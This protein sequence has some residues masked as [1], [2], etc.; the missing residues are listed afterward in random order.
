[1]GRQLNCRAGFTEKVDGI[2]QLKRFDIR[3]KEKVILIEDVISTGKSTFQ[4][5]KSVSF[6]GGIPSYKIYCLVNRSGMKEKN[7]LYI[8]SLIDKTMP[9]WESDEC[10]LCKEGSKGI[11]P[12]GNW[13]KLTA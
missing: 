6:A 5:W 9:M 1:M 3:T 2:L 8:K 13:D 12:K 10:P 7:G 4:T 11:R